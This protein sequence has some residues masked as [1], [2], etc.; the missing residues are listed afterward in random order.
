MPNTEQASDLR[1]P[2]GGALRA[3]GRSDLSAVNVTTSTQVVDMADANHFNG[4][5]YQERFVR[6]ICDQDIYYYWSNNA[7]AILDE[8]K[9]DGTNRD[10]QCDY[11]PAKIP[12]EEGPGG[13]YF[14]VKGAAAGIARISISNQTT[15]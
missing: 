5:H 13:R 2:L 7:S 15:P 3:D 10:Q 8:T 9:K 14:V 11:L 4:T 1:G 6:I 12:R